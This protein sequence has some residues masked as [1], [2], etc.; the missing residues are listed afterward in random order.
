MQ[1]QI[2]KPYLTKEQ[3]RFGIEKFKKLDI[4]QQEGKQRLIDSFI[5]SIYLYDDKIIF[6][7]NYKDGTRTVNLKEIESVKGSDLKCQSAP[8]KKAPFAGAF[9]CRDSIKKNQSI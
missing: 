2:A 7:F 5:N 1:E 6:T 4:S 9:L 3:I 8:M